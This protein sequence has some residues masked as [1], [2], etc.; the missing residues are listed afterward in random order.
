MKTHGN[1]S[2]IATGRLHEMISRTNTPLDNICDLFG[3]MF[4]T[5]AYKRKKQFRENV[6]TIIVN[7]IEKTIKEKNLGWQLWQIETTGFLYTKYK[8]KKFR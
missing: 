4:N 5:K 7:K 1:E 6:H 2:F 3:G 8:I